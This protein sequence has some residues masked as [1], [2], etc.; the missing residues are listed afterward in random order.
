M[1]NESNKHLY[2]QSLNGFYQL[3]KFEN[4]IELA[5]IQ[6]PQTNLEN[7]I[8][9][10]NFYLIAQCLWHSLWISP[11]NK[12]DYSNEERYNFL[13]INLFF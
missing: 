5:L 12:D 2:T 4:L 6:T 10:S 3:L 8:K 7:S 9:Q 11:I 13:N 1:K